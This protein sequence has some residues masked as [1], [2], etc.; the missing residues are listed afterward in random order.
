MTTFGG[1]GGAPC[2]VPCLSASCTHPLVPLCFSEP[3]CVSFAS[4]HT[5]ELHF[6]KKSSCLFAL[7]GLRALVEPLNPW[8][9]WQVNVTSCVTADEPGVQES[10][11]TE[12]EISPLQCGCESRKLWKQWVILHRGGDGMSGRVRGWGDEQA[13]AGGGT[14]G[15]WF[16][17]G[18]RTYAQTG[19]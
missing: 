2:L 12:G 9:L 8:K 10:H 15:V 13:V 14:M 19:F 6:W 4:F 18:M 5:H 1:D 3:L 17:A 16:P 11:S 7:K